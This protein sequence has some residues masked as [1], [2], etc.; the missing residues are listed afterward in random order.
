MTVNVLLV[1]IVLAAALARLKW[2]RCS[3]ALLASALILLL[4]AGCGP[5]PIWLMAQLQSSPAAA[6]PI[7]WG[8]RNAIV[9]LGAG[10]ERVAGSGKIEASLVAYGRI[11]KA[12]ELYRECRRPGRE[13][14]I[15]V[16]GG[17]AR[18]LGQSEAAVYADLQRLGVDAA[19]LLLET[20]SMNT[21]QNAQFSSP[22]LKAYGAD[23]VLLVSSAYHLRRAMLYFTHF[24]VHAVPVS[25][26]HVD[27]ML[28]WL[29]LSYNF[30]MADL[31]LHEY[32]GIVR[33]HV[34]NAMGWNVAATKSDAR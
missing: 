9:L 11:G 32:T 28:S 20:R 4:A 7:D 23:R 19:D 17:D 10:A 1:L 34:Y 29:P 14:K 26:D 6:A 22:L 27:G 21:W 13:C 30:A 8:Q 31:A 15:E 2:R 5:L 18:G 12:A 16:S 25:A 33:Y 24:G 3:R